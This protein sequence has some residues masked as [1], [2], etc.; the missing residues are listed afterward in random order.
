[1]VITNLLGG[2]TEEYTCGNFPATAT[3]LSST[4]QICDPYAA[5]VG[6]TGTHAANGA[7]VS[8]TANIVPVL[9]GV[10]LA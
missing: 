8:L 4:D 10:S 6:L 9:D 2:T 1:M 3:T 5:L 7:L